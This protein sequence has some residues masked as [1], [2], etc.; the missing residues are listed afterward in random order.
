MSESRGIP[1]VI[2]YRPKRVADVV[3][4]NEA[5]ELFLSWLN[6]WPNVDKK[7]ALLYGPPGCG[8]SSLIEAVANEYG[9]EL[10]EMNASD[11]RRKEDIERIALRASQQKSITASNKL[12][13]LDEVDGIASKEDAGGIE[14]V[15]SLVRVSKFPVVMAANDPWDQKLK[16]IRDIA[17]LIQFRRLT[18]KDVVKV[19]SRICTAE[20]IECDEAALE[21]IAERSGGDL[22]AA[23]NDLQ[24]VSE[25]YGTVR[26]DLVKAILRQ[27]DRELNPFETLKA[28][29]T[30]RYAWQAKAAQMQ[31]QLDYD[32]LKS[33]IAENIPYQ[34][35]DLEDVAEAFDKLSKADIY[36]GRIIR[37]GDWDL[38]SY[39]IDLMTAGVSLSVKNVQDKKYAARYQPPQK[40]SLLAKSKEVRSLLDDIV[41]IIARNLHTSKSTALSEVLPYLKA[42]FSTNSES[43][44][45]IALGLNFSEEMIKYLAGANAEAVLRK[46]RE[47]REKLKKSIVGLGLEEGKPAEKQEVKE[48]PSK[49]GGD[50]MSF[51]KGSNPSRK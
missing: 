28:I 8:K 45:R 21:E 39:A 51:I 1:W 9:F 25:G 29:F 2:K 7:A 50:L 26:L 12:I 37:T 38:L 20:R 32:Q 10:I 18:T 31:S 24:A 17:L 22:R 49:R 47:L 14:A 3:N 36:L 42:I 43:A 27:R 11:F 15:I 16:P 33:W 46:Y 35:R 34:Y 41:T 30:A 40:L 5:K 23:I 13:F 4:Q 19:L 48:K 44:A 6:K